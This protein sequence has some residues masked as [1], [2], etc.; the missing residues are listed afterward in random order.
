MNCFKNIL[1][2]FGILLEITLSA[3]VTKSQVE[4]TSGDT[5]TL[6]C[7][8]YVTNNSVI[9]WSRDDR[10]LFA[11]SLKI[12]NDDRYQLIND[13]LIIRQANINDAGDIMCQVE[14]EDRK[15]SKFVY[16]VIVLEPAGA[17]IRVGSYLAVKKGTQLALNCVGSS[18]L[19]Q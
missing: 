10:I 15:L 16:N 8:L 1:L 11:G 2:I 7:P 17:D 13:N 12:K 18:N 14:D 3:V 4:V 5:L 9:L 6:Y 19:F